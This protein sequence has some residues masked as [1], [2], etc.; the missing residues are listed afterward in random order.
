MPD[1]R[2]RD[3][4]PFRRGNEELPDGVGWPDLKRTAKRWCRLSSS[5]VCPVK[6][7]VQGLLVG[8]ID[9]RSHG[10]RDPAKLAR[11]T[12]GHALAQGLR[13][14]LRHDLPER[15]PVLT[16]EGLELLQ[17]GGGDVDRR[18]RHDAR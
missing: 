11:P 10:L 1:R 15:A 18:S 4:T 2:R 5:A 8:E 17:N 12:R 14:E 7:R 13:Q 3:R 16:L 9:E 6:R